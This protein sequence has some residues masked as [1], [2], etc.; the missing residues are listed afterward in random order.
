[1]TVLLPADGFSAV[2]GKPKAGKSTFIRQLIAAIIKSQQF[3]DREVNIPRNTG[4]VL[5]VHLDRKDRP[6]RVAEELR[7]LGI[8]GQD[9]VTRLTLMAA[10]DLPEVVPGENPSNSLSNRLEWL[11]NEV[12]RATPH[13]IVIDLLQQFVCSSNVN[14]YAEALTSL[15]RLQDALASIKYQGALLAAIHSRKATNSEQPCD[16][17]LGSTAF[18]G[19]FTTLVLLKQ[20]RAEGTYTITSDQTEREDPWGEIDETELVRNPGRTL[21][22]GRPVAQLKEDR[23]AAKMEADIERVLSF[24]ADHPGSQTDEII[25]SLAMAKGRYLEIVDTVNDLLVITRARD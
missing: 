2:I 15:N 21:S 24:I 12:L 1:M 4:R 11:K 16:D 23:K 13:L 9:E 25:S 17:T 8:T 18:R 3:L 19:S 5:Y 10:E 6:A 14:D 7:Q 20:N 22:L